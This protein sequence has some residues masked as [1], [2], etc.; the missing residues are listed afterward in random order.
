MLI[1]GGEPDEAINEVRE[2]IESSLAPLLPP[3]LTGVGEL[4]ALIDT[5]V[6]TRRDKLHNELEDKMSRMEQRKLS[7][8]GLPQLEEWHDF[9]LLRSL[10][11]QAVDAAA[12]SSDH[13]LAHSIIRDKLVNFGVWLYN[14][15]V[16]KPMGNAMFRLLETEAVVLGD[17]DAE[18][19]NKKNAGCDL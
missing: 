3:K 8:K 18:R 16:E 4:P 7:N 12:N 1:G 10:Y 6:Q 19:L 17:A 9:I 11:R 5:A 13:S 2:L 15:R 14:V